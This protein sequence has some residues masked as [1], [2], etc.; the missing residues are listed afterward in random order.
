MTKQYF[1]VEGLDDEFILKSLLPQELLQET[2]VIVAGGYSAALSV[3]QTLLTL[4]PLPIVIFF[5]T[6]TFTEKEIEEK[7]QFIN[8]YL[9]RIFQ[10]K[11][12]LIPF[13]PDIEVLFLDNKELLE[14]FVKCQV[15]DELWQKIH[16]Q[17]RQVIKKIAG[18]KNKYLPFLQSHL[19]IDI[20]EKLQ[21]TVLLK[22]IVNQLSSI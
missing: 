17:P 10:N 4:T 20:I 15:D 18:G 5:D 1:V 19:T 6:D 2:K 13:V 11:L 8:S 16:Q 3:A 21:E 22:N 7:K 12:L 14:A 9:K